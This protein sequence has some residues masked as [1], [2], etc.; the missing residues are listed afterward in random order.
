[1]G[2]T[3]TDD[4]R[5]INSAL[6]PATTPNQAITT[7]NAAACTGTAKFAVEYPLCLVGIGSGT[8]PA[9]YAVPNGYCYANACLE[10]L[11]AVGTATA[12]RVWRSSQ[13]FRAARSCLATLPLRRTLVDAQMR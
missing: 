7:T 9:S 5:C 1:M 2:G 8:S 6:L 4:E 3:K 13:L 10:D 12:S 11:A